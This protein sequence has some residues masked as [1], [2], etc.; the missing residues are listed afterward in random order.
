M[1]VGVAHGGC[2]DVG[3]PHEMLAGDGGRGYSLGAK[4][5][6]VLACS[7]GAA[8]PTDEETADELLAGGGC[9]DGGACGSAMT[10]RQ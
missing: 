1:L 9:A 8:W 10:G 3:G 2:F 5:D 4:G 7:A 6:E